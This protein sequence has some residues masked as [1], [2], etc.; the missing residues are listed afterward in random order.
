MGDGQK[1][2]IAKN[3]LHNIKRFSSTDGLKWLGAQSRESVQQQLKHARVG[4]SW[5]DESMNDTVEY[6]TKILEYG[7]A[8]CA[9][10]VNRNPL[11]EELLGKDYPLF[12]NSA[13]EFKQQLVKALSDIQVC[14]Q[15][16]DSLNKLAQRHTLSQRISDISEW[17]NEA[18]PAPKPTRKIRVLVAGHDLKFFTLLQKKLEATGQFE[19]LTDQWQGHNKHDEVKRDSE[20]V[21]PKQCNCF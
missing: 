20:P 16:A 19:F 8:G 1:W 18:P 2:L 5:R 13:K 17:L 9:A 21:C 3:G 4:L 7:G 10:I 6:S 11:H 15:A 14:Q 12:A